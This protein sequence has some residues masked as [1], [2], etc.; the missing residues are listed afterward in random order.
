[1]AE[2]LAARQLFNLCPAA[3]RV[4]EL[5]RSQVGAPK[6][7]ERKEEAFRSRLSARERDR[8]D[9]ELDASRDVVLADE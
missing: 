3:L 4:H 2:L 9:R 8:V 5:A 7:V 6:R 1:M